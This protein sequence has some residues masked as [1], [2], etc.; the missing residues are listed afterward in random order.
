[1]SAPDSLPEALKWIR[2]KSESGGVVVPHSL[3]VTPGLQHRVGGNDLLLK[4]GLSLLPLA[5][6]EDGGEVRD[7]LLGVLSLS[8]T[9]LSSD[10]DGLIAAGVGHALVGTLS[11]GEDVRPALVPPL[12]DVQLHGAE[13][14][15]R[16]PLVGVDGDTE[17]TGVGVDQLVLVSNDGVPEDT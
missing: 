8:G 17:E 14:V 3:G 5:G 13:G 6:G 7:D 1:M 16:V 10:E 12:A 15:D 9:G 2:M 4:G 11:D